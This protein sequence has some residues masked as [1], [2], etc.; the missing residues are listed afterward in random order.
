MRRSRCR[1]H[2]DP[3]RRSNARSRP[4][5]R[6]RGAG[7]RGGRAELGDRAIATG[8]LEELLSLEDLLS[9]VRQSVLHPMIVRR[10]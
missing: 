1:R 2:A 10:C 6:D 5:L 8:E 4:Y 7:T 9:E 3:P